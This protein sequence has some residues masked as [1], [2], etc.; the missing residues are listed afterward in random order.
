MWKA[1]FRL[2]TELSSR[3]WISRLTG[4][5]AQSRISRHMIPRFARIYGISV[6]D[7]EK[8]VADYTSLNDFFTRRL[9]PGARPI[10]PEINSVS[11]P[12]DALITGIGEISDGQLL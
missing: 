4:R 6:H 5:L 11:S 9:K 8:A 2:L 3:K 1:T 12:V 10:C 7:A